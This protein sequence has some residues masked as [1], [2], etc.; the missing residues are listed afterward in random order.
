M[1]LRPSRDTWRSWL[2]AAITLLSACSSPDRSDEY[3]PRPASQLPEYCSNQRQNTTETDIDCGGPECNRCQVGR[4]CLRANDCASELCQGGSC[5]D[6]SCANGRK[7]AE[8]SD[9]DCGSWRCSACQPGQGCAESSDCTSGVCTNAVCSEPSCNDGLQNGAELGRD[10]GAQGCVGCRA[11]TPCTEPEHC[12]SGRCEDGA[13]GVSCPAGSAEC[14]G[15]FSVECEIEIASDPAHCGACETLCAPAH[16]LPSCV[17]GICRIEA[18][19]GS[20]QDCNGDPSDGCEANLQ[21]DPDNCTA[22][23]LA[24]SRS[25]GDPVCVA[26]TCALTCAQ[27]YDDCDHDAATGCETK[28]DDNV[29]HCGGCNRRCNAPEGE[30]P[31]CLD[32]QCQSQG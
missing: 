30:T 18:C 26:G 31:V 3:T 12:S 24:C 2:T 20:Y 22:C 27:G 7:D 6:R 25:N 11:G 5:R 32:G 8:E 15:D 14:D 10:C 23:G 4:S 29:E 21:S 28:L 13:C 1:A 9:V 19:E 17:A 16:A